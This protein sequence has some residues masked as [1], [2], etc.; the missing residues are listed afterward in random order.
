MHTIGIPS[1]L[2]VLLVA[3]DDKPTPKFPVGKETTYVTGPLDKDGYI[4]YAAA[5]NDRLSKGV[6]PETNANVL[7]WKALG[8]AP[9]GGRGMPAEFFKRLGIPELPKEGNYF[10]GLDKF[11]LEQLKLDRDDLPPLWEQQGRATQRPWAAK[12]HPHIA[13]WLTANEKPLAVVV[14]ATQRPDY[15]NPLVVSRPEN[16]PPG[17]LIGALLPGVQKCRELVAALTARAMLRVAEGK[18]DEAWQDLLASHRLGR[19]VTRGAT[20]IESL[21]GI[22]VGAVAHN[23]TLAYLDRV[24]L[25]PKQIAEHVK[26][27]QALPPRRSMADIV[28]LGER[29]M[30]L[31]SLQLIRRGGGGGLG[32]GLSPED[33][34]GLEMIDWDTA[35]RLVNKSYDKMAAAMRVQ[36]RAEREKAFDKV[37]QEL[38]ALVKEAKKAEDLVKKLKGKDAPEPKEVGEIVGRKI[39]SILMAL[40]AP[41]VRKVQIA[42]DRAEQMD[43]NLRVAFALAAY[44]RDTGRYP[45]KLDDLAPKYLAAVPGDLFSGKPLVYKPTEKGYVFYSIGAN[46][47][48][49]E[50]RWYGDDPPGDDPGVR[51]PLPELKK[52]K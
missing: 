15:F 18:P 42:S 39:G 8:P 19:L 36:D 24:K 41:A 51:M 40:L 50:G 17:S 20:L 48:D 4:D 49:E 30:G 16:G 12:D 33:L 29:L 52:K 3:A 44:H 2:V 35:L 7:L 9:E 22:A 6:T 31:D 11:A 46:G 38:D 13:A 43:R 27:L 5:L 26:D 37:E 45:A 1:I 34:Q 10:V 28:D 32:G 23:A 25:T 21:V 14:E 47:K